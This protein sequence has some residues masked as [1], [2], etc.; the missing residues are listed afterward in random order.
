MHGV[1]IEQLAVLRLG[2]TDSDPD[3][4]RM[5]RERQAH[6]FRHEFRDRGNGADDGLV[7]CLSDD[8]DP[9]VI[10]LVLDVAQ[11]EWHRQVIQ[12]AGHRRLLLPHPSPHGGVLR[13]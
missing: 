3:R 12:I 6:G 7:G 13:R 9:I 8:L 4:A 10:T 2:R 11:I 1:T 5:S